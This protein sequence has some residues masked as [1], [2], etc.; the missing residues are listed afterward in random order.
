[1]EI[2]SQC[3]SGGR[4]F[5]HSTMCKG[6]VDV[7]IQ[8]LQCTPLTGFLTMQWAAFTSRFIKEIKSCLIESDLGVLFDNMSQQCAQWPGG[9]MAPCPGSRIMQPAGPGQCSPPVLSTASLCLQSWAPRLKRDMETL[10]HIQQNATRL[11][12]LWKTCLV[13]MAEG[14]AF[15]ESWGEEAQGTSPLYSHMKGGWGEEGATPFCHACR[16]RTREIAPNWDGR[17][18]LGKIILFSLLE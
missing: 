9:P 7:W 3:H 11:V 4:E 13:E 16:E 5:V 10:E 15:V 1:M 6:G 12:N 2:P 14:A 17:F 8:E 18:R